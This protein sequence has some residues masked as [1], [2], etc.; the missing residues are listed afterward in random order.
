MCSSLL[1]TAFSEPDQEPRGKGETKMTVTTID[2]LDRSDM[3]GKLMDQLR[4]N[5]RETAIVTIDMPRGHLDPE[6]ATM[7]ASPEDSRRVIANAAEVLDFARAQGVPVIHVLLI[8][9]PITGLGSEGMAH[10]F[11]Q[12]VTAL[13]DEANRPSP[14]RKTPD[15]T[16]NIN[17][18]PPTGASPPPLH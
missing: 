16:H 7:P 17:G 2:I 18:L 6:I 9:R 11:W 5:P 14:G 3:Q 13:T 8:F 10:P 15:H 4:L 1:T 12:A